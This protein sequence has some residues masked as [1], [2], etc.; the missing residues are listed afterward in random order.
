V[1]NI[2][3]WPFVLK[4]GVLGIGVPLTIGLLFWKAQQGS[5]YWYTT[6]HLIAAI[7]I[8]IHAGFLFGGM[9]GAVLWIWKRRYGVVK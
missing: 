3:F 9:V 7:V 6:T 5:L 4:R 2:P 1:T 8:R